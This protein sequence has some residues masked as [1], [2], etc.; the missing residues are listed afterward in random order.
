M[1]N[2]KRNVSNLPNLKVRLFE[3]RESDNSVSDE[4][5]ETCS[6]N[7]SL[8]LNNVTSKISAPNL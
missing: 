4:H 1:P 3:K 7:D 2:C 8:K 5:D 6:M